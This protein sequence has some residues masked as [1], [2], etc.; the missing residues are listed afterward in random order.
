VKFCI[1]CKHLIKR[2]SGPLFW[3]CAATERKA[4]KSDESYAEALVTGAGLDPG[5]EYDFCSVCRR[6]KGKCGR[7]GK[8]WE[9]K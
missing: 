6:K 4:E 8:L 1:E 3:L 9:A 7:E 2:V 5:V